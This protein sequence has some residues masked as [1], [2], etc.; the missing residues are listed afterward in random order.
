MQQSPQTIVIQPANPQVVYVPE[1]NPTV[2]YGTPYVTP[3]YSTADLVATGVIAFGAGLAIGA[4]MSGGYGWG[5][6]YWSCNWYG[7]AAYYHGGAYYG[8]APGMGATTAQCVLLRSLRQRPRL[9]WL[10][11]RHR[12]I[13]RGA[14][15]STAYGTKKQDR[16]TTQHGAYGATH[17]GSNAY[18][19]W[20]SSTVSKNG[21]TVDTQHYSSAAGNYGTARPPAATI[22]HR[23][24]KRLQEHRQRMAIVGFGSDGAHGW[25]DSSS[26]GLRRHTVEAAGDQQP[27][28][29][30]PA[31]G[32]R[33]AI[34]LLK[35]T[36]LGEWRRRRRLGRSQLRR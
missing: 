13:A 1:Y 28:A 3:G 14:S 32:R 25:G 20:G 9:R 23:Q 34:A 17:Q 29:D 31:A 22:R 18:S 5:Y 10:Q 26:S 2:V 30:S 24:R 15:T 33:L 16:R 11:P 8:N 35:R 12:H 36:R 27:S 7:G 6:S 21:Q 4:M 19:N